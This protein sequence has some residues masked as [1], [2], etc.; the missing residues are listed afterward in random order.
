LAGKEVA[1]FCQDH[2]ADVL[3]KSAHYKEHNYEA[4]LKVRSSPRSSVRRLV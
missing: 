4:A 2:L 1:K 3:V